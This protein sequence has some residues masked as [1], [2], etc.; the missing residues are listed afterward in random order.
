M[1][2]VRM[3]RVWLVLSARGAA[4]GVGCSQLSLGSLLSQTRTVQ[5][6][7]GGARRRWGR[8]AQRLGA[9]HRV[10]GPIGSCTRTCSSELAPRAPWALLP[11]TAVRHSLAG[12][13]SSVCFAASERVSPLHSVAQ[14]AVG[15]TRSGTKSPLRR[16]ACCIFICST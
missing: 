7:K 3:V 12:P 15:F 5:D 13:A 11:L 6:T 10:L 9:W 2:A 1:L 4:L 8:H 14:D 16:C